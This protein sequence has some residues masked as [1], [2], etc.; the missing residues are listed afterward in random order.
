MQATQVNAARFL[1]LTP[2]VVADEAMNSVIVA[3][4]RRLATEPDAFDAE[5]HVIGD[6]VQAGVVVFRERS[7][8]ITDVA[9]V[10]AFD[11]IAAL[12]ASY[13]ELDTIEAHDPHAASIFTAYSAKTGRR[14][15]PAMAMGAFALAELV[16]PPRPPGIPRS[17]TVADRALLVEWAMRFATEAL[18]EEDPSRE[19]TERLV[20]GR[21]DPDF[22]AGLFVW[23][24]DGEVVSMTG[25]SGATET[26]IRV[27]LVYTPP[28]HRGRGFAAA[29]CA[30]QARHLLEIG[31]E[32]IYLFTD[33]SNPTSNALYERI[34]YRRVG[35]LE[36]RTVVR[37][38]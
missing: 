34:G 36:R 8:L 21:L 6:P 12:L 38:V 15:G 31:Y 11:A 30:A 26:G 19:A 9:D 5:H 29:L 13:P 3:T 24:L 10:A 17:A 4:A 22:P 2:A 28:E 7:A 32:N 14:T 35:T 16:E 23:E 20:D 18:S 37:D 27:N 33:L 1:E 25:H